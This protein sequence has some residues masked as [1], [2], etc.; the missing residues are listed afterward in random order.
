MSFKRV[1]IN[2]SFIIPPDLL[3]LPNFTYPWKYLIV[4]PMK[5]NQNIF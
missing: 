2:E 3:E 4:N 1:N 5:L